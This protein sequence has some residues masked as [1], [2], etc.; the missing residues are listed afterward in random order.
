MK[1]ST[2]LC[3]LVFFARTDCA[4]A[5]SI[6][7]MG[8]MW[9]PDAPAVELGSDGRDIIVDVEGNV[10]TTGMLQA[11][12]STESFSTYKLNS[13]D[14][15]HELSMSEVGMFLMKQ[16]SDGEVLWSKV[17]EHLWTSASLGITSTGD[18]VLAGTFSA[19]VDFDPS[20]E[21]YEVEFT[22]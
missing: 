6:E 19:T 17:W 10:Y 4:V 3:H 21:T 8:A 2:L 13:N 1:K 12:N 20:A 7:W 15:G 5:Q 22:G 11:S 16:N 14:P 9:P 18:I